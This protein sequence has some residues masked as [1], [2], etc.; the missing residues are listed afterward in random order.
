L[1]KIEDIDVN[2]KF[3]QSTK[4]NLVLIEIAKSKDQ[5]VYED[6][7]IDLSKVILTKWQKLYAK[8]KNKKE[9][10]NGKRK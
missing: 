8:N 7:L 5:S 3:I 10:M 2:F 1:K 9:D 4:L 6:S